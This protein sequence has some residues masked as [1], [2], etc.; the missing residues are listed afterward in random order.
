[1]WSVFLILDIVK[2]VNWYLI[3][4]LSCI[5]FFANDVDVFSYTY[6]T[7]VYL[8]WTVFT[9]ILHIKFFFLFNF[10]FFMYSRYEFSIR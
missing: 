5:S 3:M 2:G 6:L 8:W 1:M 4:I 10:E 7:S 9:N